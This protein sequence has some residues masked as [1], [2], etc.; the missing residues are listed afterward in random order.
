MK[1]CR[2]PLLVRNWFQVAE[3][4]ELR[5]ESVESET[6]ARTGRKLGLAWDSVGL[7]HATQFVP[8]GKSELGSERAARPGGSGGSV[9]T[10]VHVDGAACPAH[11]S[12]WWMSS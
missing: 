8:S 9:K 4:W 11:P 5:R 10:R 6:E 12:L 1:L 2:L 7:G 3:N